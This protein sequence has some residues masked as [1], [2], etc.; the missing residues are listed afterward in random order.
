MVNQH[1]NQRGD[2]RSYEFV[3][4]IYCKGSPRT[5]LESIAKRLGNGV[6]LVQLAERV[7]WIIHFSSRCALSL[8]IWVASAEISFS[9]DIER[10]IIT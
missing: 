1:T 8:P 10:G 7:A 6:E 4:R 3:P 2:T 5:R 9:K